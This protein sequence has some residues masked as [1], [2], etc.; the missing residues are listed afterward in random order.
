MKVFGHTW[1]PSRAA[2]ALA[3]LVAMVFGMFTARALCTEAVDAPE[4]WGISAA[5]Y[6][7]V[8]AV[9]CLAV[10]PRRE[11]LSLRHEAGMVVVYAALAWMVGQHTGVTPEHVA[12]VMGPAVIL[13]FSLGFA[14]EGRA[15]DASWE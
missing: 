5:L 12:Q 4:W 6:V 14:E 1:S 7:S 11:A 2:M 9:R 15:A 13:A 10:R 8:S 3:G